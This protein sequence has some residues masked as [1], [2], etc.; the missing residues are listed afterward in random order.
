MFLFR[1]TKHIAAI[2]HFSYY[3]VCPG[4][5]EIVRYSK[6]MNNVSSGI[7]WPLFFESSQVLFSPFFVLFRSLF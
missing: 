3:K 4:D 5:L 7:Y 1:Q 2:I 6:H